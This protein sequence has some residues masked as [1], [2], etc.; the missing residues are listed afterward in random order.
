MIATPPQRSSEA[1]SLEIVTKVAERNGVEPEELTPPLH[2]AIDT[3]ALN[4]LFE[5]TKNG[6][7]EGAV[8][9]E[10]N[11]YTVKVVANG[12]V[13]VEIADLSQ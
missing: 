10:Y 11:G 6:P 4:N 13:D 1:V 12:S 9:F 5:P 7:R 2:S 3:E 8:T